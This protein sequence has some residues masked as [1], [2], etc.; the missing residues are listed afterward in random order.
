MIALARVLL[1]CAAA[2]AAPGAPAAAPFPAPAE[3]AREAAAQTIV[4]L[5]D[6]IGVD[7]QEAVENG[8]VKN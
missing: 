6:Y 5:L 8:K 4:H 3:G 1:L 7:Y 2:L